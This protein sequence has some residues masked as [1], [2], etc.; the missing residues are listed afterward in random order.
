MNSCDYKSND[1]KCVTKE[2]IN[3]ILDGKWE[4]CPCVIKGSC[5]ESKAKYEKNENKYQSE[6][7]TNSKCCSKNN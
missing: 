1:P 7:V 3:E 5:K 2:K 4:D 6:N